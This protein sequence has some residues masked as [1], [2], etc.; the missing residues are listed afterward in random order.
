[1]IQQSSS[2]DM[3]E[4]GMLFWNF[5]EQVPVLTDS[6]VGDGTFKVI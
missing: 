4:G 2:I 5:E 1:M 6:L 3:S